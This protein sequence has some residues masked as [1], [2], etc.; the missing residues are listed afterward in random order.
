MRDLP[1]LLAAARRDPSRVVVE[2]FHALKHA[3][4]FG[5]AVD[6]AVTPDPGGLDRLVRTLAPDLVGSVATDTGPGTGPAAVR[7]VTVDPSLWR[8]LCPQDLPTPALAVARR[9]GPPE[10]RT[11]ARDRAVVLLDRPTH[12]GNLGAV[13]RV[14]AAADAG[15]VVAVGGVDPWHPAAVR[16]AAGLQFALPVTRVADPPP[17][18]RPLIAVDPGGAPLPRVRIP[19]SAVLAFGSERTGLRPSVLAR[20]ESAVAIPMR[21]G[22]SSLNLA[23]AV[24]VVLYH[25]RV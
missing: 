2:G 10:L 3:V 13:V 4:R 19:P 15:A 17:L 25:G 5:A 23:T 6:W 14:A 16:G 22:V 1:R 11:V 8:R 9:P 12:A 7:A 20:A 18:D 24:A 21:P